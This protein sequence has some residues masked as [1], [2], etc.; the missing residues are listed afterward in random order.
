MLVDRV[1]G[2]HEVPLGNRPDLRVLSARSSLR[3]PAAPRLTEP[4]R[5]VLVRHTWVAPHADHYRE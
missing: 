4:H 2:G 5:D 3:L 1:R